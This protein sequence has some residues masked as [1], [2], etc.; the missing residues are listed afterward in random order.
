MCLLSSG[1]SL[2]TLFN[3]EPSTINF[4]FPQEIGFSFS[5]LPS[6]S[7]IITLSSLMARLYSARL[8]INGL[9]WLQISILKQALNIRPL[10]LYLPPQNFQ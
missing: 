3:T 9:L 1:C 8:L 2:I 4:L 5:H 6:P 10:G 7:N